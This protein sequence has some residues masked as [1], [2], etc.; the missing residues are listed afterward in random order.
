MRR[1]IFEFKIYI[2]ELETRFVVFIFV[3]LYSYTV[4]FFNFVNSLYEPLL[5]LTVFL[6]INYEMHLLVYVKKSIS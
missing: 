5:C 3:L 4:D 1:L 2:V 6:Q